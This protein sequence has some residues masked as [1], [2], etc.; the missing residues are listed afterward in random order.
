METKMYTQQEVDEIVGKVKERQ[1]EKAE[2]KISKSYVELS[3]YQEL[4]NRY[5]EVVNKDKISS[6]KETFKTNNGNMDAFDDFINTNKQLLDLDNEG[7]VKAIK[8][9]QET[10][11]YFFNSNPP[12]NDY[13]M[14]INEK[15]VLEELTGNSEDYF[16]DTLYPMI[17]K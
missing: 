6:L 7:Q 10:K 3:K 14:N 2:A 12:S 17:K 8:E 4:E 9:L 15:S 13:Q 1:Q 16:E 5:N 11:K